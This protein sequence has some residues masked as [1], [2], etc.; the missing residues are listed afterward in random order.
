MSREKF[1]LPVEE[2]LRRNKEFADQAS[3]FRQED[4]EY[5]RKYHPEKFTDATVAVTT[6][7]ISKK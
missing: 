6:G 5:N 3:K 7:G 1:F 4:D 2:V